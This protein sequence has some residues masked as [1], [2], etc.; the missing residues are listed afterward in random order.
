MVVGR[1]DVSDI[2]AVCEGPTTLTVCLNEDWTPLVQ[3][4]WGA[5]PY[6]TCAAGQIQTPFN[7]SKALP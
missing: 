1:A 6:L 7:A 4:F 2:F 3:D 5:G